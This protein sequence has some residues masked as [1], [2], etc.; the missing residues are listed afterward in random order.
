[1][2]P[3]SEHAPHHHDHHSKNEGEFVDE[4]LDSASS[5]S[6]VEEAGTKSNVPAVLS[7]AE[8][9]SDKKASSFIEQEEHV[10]GAVSMNV[11]LTYLFGG[12]RAVIMLLFF[13]SVLL[14][15]AKVSQVTSLRWSDPPRSVLI[16]ILQR[17]WL[18]LWSDNSLGSHDLKF[19]LIIYLSF[20]VLQT[21]A[22]ASRQFLYLIFFL[23]KMNLP[24]RELLPY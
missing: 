20:A 4:D 23:C 5:E 15:L 10:T 14:E 18:A 12:G 16:L 13:L 24:N 11:Y 22:V 6:A 1:M 21:I 3:P 2:K 9:I 17:E 19:Y 8:S 7:S